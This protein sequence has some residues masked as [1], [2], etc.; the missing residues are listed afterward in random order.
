MPLPRHCKHC[1]GDC[2][3]DCLMPGDEGLC[4]HRPYRRLSVREWIS[5][6]RTPTFWRLVF[7]GRR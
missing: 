5:L 2:P 7:F 6:T 1:L 4:I 3:G